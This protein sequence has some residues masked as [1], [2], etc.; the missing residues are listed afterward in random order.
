MSL[1]DNLPTELARIVM[2]SNT[3]PSIY[4]ST[5]KQPKVTGNY[6]MGLYEILI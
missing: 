3:S 4:S 5:H 2:E 6:V 1:L